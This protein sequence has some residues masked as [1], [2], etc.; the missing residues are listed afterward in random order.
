MRRLQQKQ[1]A[2]RP[3]TVSVGIIDY[4]QL[5]TQAVGDL[6]II[7]CIS[8][9]LKYYNNSF[10]QRENILY[11]TVKSECIKNIL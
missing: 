2:T 3:S 1:V 5:G 7:S 9:W 10:V 8:C 11:A 6:G 4:G